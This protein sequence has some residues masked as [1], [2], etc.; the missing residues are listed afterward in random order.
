[1]LLNTL[2]SPG[3]VAASLS[4]LALGAS[5]IE[6]SKRDIWSAARV[7]QE[8]PDVSYNLLAVDFLPPSVIQSSLARIAA[9]LAAGTL[10]PLRAISHPLGS[11]ASA[12]RQMVQA[13]HV[14]KVVVSAGEEGALPG[15]AR[16]GKLLV[17]GGTGG[18]GLAMAAWAVGARGAAP[19][20]LLS[21]AGRLGGDAAK[22]RSLLLSPACVSI[23]AADTGFAADGDA[24]GAQAADLPT[25]TLLHAAGVLQD[26]L[27]ERQSASSLRRVLAP[28]LGAGLGA[29]SSELRGLDRVLL[30]SSVASLLGAAGQGNYAAANSALDA[31]AHRAARRGEAFSALQWGAWASS[32]MASAAVLK[33]LDRIGQGAITAEQ[34]LLALASALRAPPARLPAQLAVNAFDWSKYLEQFA[35]AVPAF[36]EAFA[37]PKAPDAVDVVAGVKAKSLAKKAP[38]TIASSAA[39]PEAIK[40][41]VTATVAAAAAEVVGP[42]VDEDE[43]LMAAGL[44]SLGSVEFANM[45]GQRLGLSMPGTLIFDYP[46]LNAITGY[47]STQLLKQHQAAGAAAGPEQEEDDEELDYAS[48]YSAYSERALAPSRRAAPPSR[49]VALV[50]MASQALQGDLLGQQAAA[51]GAAVGSA[52]HALGCDAIQR[53]PLARWDLDL[54]ESL[55]GD[56][57]TLSAQFGSFMQSIELFDAA[58]YGMSAGEAAIMDPQ[59]RIVLTLATEVLIAGRGL[60]TGKREGGG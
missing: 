22:A 33:R 28:K 34:G 19:L 42:G 60:H 21:R 53:V 41:Q 54:A 5:L 44:D 57:Y 52:L 9:S 35:P 18:L 27:L 10:R 37:A 23:S 8:R 13:T 46:S 48:D 4:A 36:Y 31:L 39:D 17:T 25:A 56:P 40:A 45:L 55:V 29:L 11:L 3:M 2:T 26:S 16:G 32:G 51:N 12:F 38:T 14:G 49:P 59:H 30:F 20:E 50:G 6:I 58:A 1:M 15:R 7:A 43:P 47:L 24:A